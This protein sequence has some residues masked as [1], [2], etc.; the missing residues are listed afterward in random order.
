ME[1]SYG[2]DISK[3][4]IYSPYKTPPNFALTEERG[5]KLVCVKKSQGTYQDPAF[6]TIWNALKLHPNIKRTAYHWFN[7]YLESRPQIDAFLA[8]L[9]PED[10]TAPMWLD[11]EQPHSTY[12]SRVLNRM[13]EMLYAIKEWSR[14]P[15][16]IYT[17]KSKFD[18]YYSNKPGWGKDWMLVVANY[19]PAYPSIPIGWETWDGW[20]FSADQNGLG[21][22]FGYQSRSVDMDI[23]KPQMLGEV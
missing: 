17:S 23:L 9:T 16:A 6:G 12:K 15:V 11:V 21:K 18:Y 3:W 7:P 20:Q 1:Y 19:G 2:N 22:F 10:I 5:I 4:Q 8:G 13:I 14:R